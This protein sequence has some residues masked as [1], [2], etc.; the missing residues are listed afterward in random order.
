MHRSM[1]GYRSIGPRRLGRSARTH[2]RPHTLP[3]RSA[4]TLSLASYPLV[5][6][7]LLL[8]YHSRQT[9]PIPRLPTFIDRYSRNIESA[10]FDTFIKEDRLINRMGQQSRMRQEVRD[11]RSEE[12][13]EDWIEK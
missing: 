5:E 2:L 9:F 8:E 4:L 10:L 11:P 3:S 6:P 7:T 13:E 1:K 12:T